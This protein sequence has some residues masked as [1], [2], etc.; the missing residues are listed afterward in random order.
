[1]PKTPVN[2]LTA[3]INREP[4][5]RLLV[6]S[7]AWTSF[8]CLIGTFYGWWNMKPFACYVYL[9]A[10]VLL[11]RLAWKH[12]S[13]LAG[14][15]IIVGALGGIVA[16][17]AYDL[18]RLPFVLGGAPLFKPFARFGELLLGQNDPQWLVQ[19]VGWSYHFSN[20]A[21]LGI[22]LLAA[23]W[24]PTRARLFWGA[25]VWALTVE[26]LLLLTP[27]TSFFGLPLDRRFVILTVSAHL[28]FGFVLGWWCMRRAPLLST[29]AVG[30][31]NSI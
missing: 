16:A 22:M 17:V 6:F 9:P 18:F 21:A 20:G 15:W 12:R 28:I 19:S 7:L 8:A 1:L 29:R 10:I 3:T 30:H 26:A 23:L 25:V 11:V 14:Q 13:G 31:E 24:R 5:L 4:F 27:Y 2:A